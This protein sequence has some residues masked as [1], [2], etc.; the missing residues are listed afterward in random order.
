MTTDHPNQPQQQGI[1]EIHRAHNSR[2][3]ADGWTGWVWCDRQSWP[4][5]C[6]AEAIASLIYFLAD[7]CEVEG[8]ALTPERVHEE[9][10]LYTPVEDDPVHALDVSLDFVREVWG[11]EVKAGFEP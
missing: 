5:D 9:C 4:Y 7:L 8:V 10:C 1:H 6:P 2:M 11:E 3:N